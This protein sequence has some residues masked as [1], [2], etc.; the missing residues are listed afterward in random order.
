MVFPDINSLLDELDKKGIVSLDN[1]LIRRIRTDSTKPWRYLAGDTAHISYQEIGENDGVSVRKFI[2]SACQSH[3]DPV[4][5][6]IPSF[7]GILE[8]E[9]PLFWVD[10]IVGGRMTT[11]TTV[12]PVMVYQYVNHVYQSQE[13]LRETDW[14]YRERLGSGRVAEGGRG[15]TVIEHNGANSMFSI[16]Q[17]AGNGDEI[18]GFRISPPTGIEVFNPV[19]KEWEYPGGGKNILIFNR[20]P[21]SE[22]V[23]NKAWNYPGVERPWALGDTV[24]VYDPNNP[25]VPN[26]V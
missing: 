25:F 6:T 1:T 17:A 14:V 4:Q 24:L 10:G 20:N 5:F 9:I 21:T 11:Y 8:T 26:G 19:T 13:L 2:L 3:L 23:Q 12:S 7:S 16:T 22:E 15:Q 18:G